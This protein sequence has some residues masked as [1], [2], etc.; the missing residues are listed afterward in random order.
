MGSWVVIVEHHSEGR[1]DDREVLG[2]AGG[3]R[4]QAL[5]T[6]RSIVH[7]YLPRPRITEKWRQVYRLAD[8]ESY[9]VIIRGTMTQWHCTLRVAELVADSRDPSV[10]WRAQAEDAGQPPAHP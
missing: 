9:V 6:L 3:T 4:E 2:G 10:A 8:R 5:D 7:T 1:N